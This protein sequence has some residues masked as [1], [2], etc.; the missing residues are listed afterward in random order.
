MTNNID[1]SRLTPEQ[2]T[3][4]LARL[5][6]LLHQA[7]ID[8]HQK[9]SPTLSDAEYDRLKQRNGALEAQFP[10][11][12][13]SDSPTEQI[14]AAAAEGFTKVTHALPMLS[15]SNAF[16]AEDVQEF[17]G[18]ILRYLGG[19]EATALAYTAEPKIDGLSLS[20]RYEDG[21][22]VQAATRGDGQVGENVT[23]NA[24]NAP[25]PWPR[26]NEPR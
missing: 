20:L 15:L 5:A 6:R 7:N 10:D 17:E 3:A 8:Y 18:R 14:G 12:K 22:L 4:E 26:E 11:L 25:T 13:R 19:N 21:R 9:D 16:N 24:R 1:V 23:E 2:A